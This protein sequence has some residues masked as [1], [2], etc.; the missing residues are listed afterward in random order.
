MLHAVLSKLPK[1]LDLDALISR[2]AALFSEHP[3]Q[4]LPFRSWSKISS[5]SVLKTTRDSK[6]VAQ[7]SLQYG[8][9]L[10]AKQATEIQVQESRKRMREHAMKVM[11]K[12]RRPAQTA[13]AAFLIA[14]LALYMR[15]SFDAGPGTSTVASITSF[16]VG[17]WHSLTERL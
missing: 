10:F 6:Q 7:Q 13:G 11:R 9:Q 4:A 1:P 8:E 16:A 17:L 15:K 5:S 12:Y 3:P 14:L 2:T